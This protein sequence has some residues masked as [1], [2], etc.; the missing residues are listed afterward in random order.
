M[1]KKDM[2]TTI[3]TEYQFVRRLEALREKARAAE[4]AVPA[5]E[6][7]TEPAPAPEPPKGHWQTD[8][9]P[10]E[11]GPGEAVEH[12]GGGGYRSGGSVR[13]EW[14]S[15]E[16]DAEGRPLRVRVPESHTV[17]MPKDDFVAAGMRYKD[18]RQLISRRD[19]SSD[20]P[21]DI[22][23]REV[24]MMAERFPCFDSSD[25]LYE[26]RCFRWFYLC[27]DGKLTCVYY[28]DTADTVT[29]TEDLQDLDKKCWEHM[30][31]LGCFSREDTDA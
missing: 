19:G 2:R 13:L 29:V 15:R 4:P 16:T 25:Y 3:L 31:K 17:T 12:K 28:T 26:D 20:W 23:G 27:L 9:I 22:Y 24:L 8:M 11:V 5:P 14:I 21:A 6:E 10:R 30:Q 18:I 1:G 7:E